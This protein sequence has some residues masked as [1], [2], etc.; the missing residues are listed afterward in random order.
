MRLEL[1]PKRSLIQTAKPHKIISQNLNKI[2]LLIKKHPA[3]QT[4]K[5]AKNRI[6]PLIKLQNPNTHSIPQEFI[7]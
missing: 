5:L 2:Q 1:A 6:P 4:A 7:P 3:E